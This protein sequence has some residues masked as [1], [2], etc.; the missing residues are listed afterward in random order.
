LQLM[1]SGITASTS[2]SEP[3][4]I[5]IS[6][7][8]IKSPVAGAPRTSAN[9][10][11]EDQVLKL[12]S[13]ETIPVSP[14]STKIDA[15]GSFLL[16][17]LV[18]GE[19]PTFVILDGNPQENFDVILDTASHLLLAVKRGEIALNVF[20]SKTVEENA[21]EAKTS[22]W[23]AYSPPPVSMSM[24]YSPESK[25]NQWR[26][27]WTNGAFIAAVLLDRQNW[28]SQDG[29]SRRQW[30]DLSEEFDGG[31][32]R[33]FRFGSIGTINFEQPWVYTIFAATNSFD[34]GYG[35]NDDI[36]SLSF[37]DYRIDI[38]SFKRT[39]VSIGKQK[40]PISMERLMSALNLPGSERTALS[41]T[42]LTSRNF[43]IVTNGSIFKDRVAWGFGIFNDWYEE[44]LDFED[45]S[46]QY[47]ARFTWLPWQSEDES[48]LFHV[49]VAV[50]YDDAKELLSYGSEPEF[51]KGPKM[52]QTDPFPAEYSLTTNLE[53]SWRKGP[54]WIHSEFNFV[55]ISSPEFGDPA[56]TGWFVQGSYVVTGEMRDYKMPGGYFQGIK[57]ANP[58]TTGGLGALELT[59]RFT[60]TDLRDGLIDGGEMDIAT[61]GFNWFLRSDLTFS[62]Y[63]RHVWSDNFGEV[64]ESDGFMFRLIFLI[65]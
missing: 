34:K 28:F 61:A 52:I 4:Q 35:N 25:W 26:T 17:E 5:L 12:V 43:G 42:F 49:G 45:A 38:P 31:E 37:L 62:F 55:D 64:G 3:E 48:N 8:L 21:P 63:Y 19:K 24:T 27:P 44:N 56:F 15:G 47:T 54:W 14:G 6:H 50:R 58:T 32:V 59:A 11:L 10:L 36:D 13:S 40:E 57:V 22:N 33:A 1:P 41:D 7:V 16:G 9:L 65:E 2:G 30:G 39:I 23:L 53:F 51:N 29:A 20:G 46:T 60:S 18:P